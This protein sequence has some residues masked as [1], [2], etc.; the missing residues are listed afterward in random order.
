MELAEIHALKNILLSNVLLYYYIIV[1]F[2][3][4]YKKKIFVCNKNIVY[5]RIITYKYV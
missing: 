5:I 2:K 1:V 4:K 3:I